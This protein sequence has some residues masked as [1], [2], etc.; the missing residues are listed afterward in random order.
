MR[1]FYPYYINSI[2]NAAKYRAELVLEESYP[3]I[4]SILDEIKH[5]SPLITRA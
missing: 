4:I 5:A 3:K 2:K 1:K